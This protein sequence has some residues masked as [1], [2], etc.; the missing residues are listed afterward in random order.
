[1]SS[2]ST[3]VY[4]PY[5]PAQKLRK[6]SAQVKAFATFNAKE[7]QRL[8]GRSAV[9]AAGAGQ[10]AAKRVGA[11]QVTL[12]SPGR[13]SERRSILVYV[14]AVRASSRRTTSIHT[15]LRR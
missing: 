12:R 4:L 13:R 8:L 10:S 9:I 3:I 2:S 5:K 1:M 7:W 11:A 15:L 6:R 14:V